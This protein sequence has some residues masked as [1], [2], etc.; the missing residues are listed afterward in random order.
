MSKGGIGP[1]QLTCRLW[2]NPC[3]DLEEEAKVRHPFRWLHTCPCLSSQLSPPPQRSTVNYLPRASIAI[4]FDSVYFLAFFYLL[5]FPHK[6]PDHFLEILLSSTNP[7]QALLHFAL[8]EFLRSRSSP[9]LLSAGGEVGLQLHDSSFSSIY[10]SPE[11]LLVAFS[12][13]SQHPPRSPLWPSALIC[14]NGSV[15]AGGCR[16]RRELG[17]RAPRPGVQCSRADSGRLS[18]SLPEPAHSQV[19]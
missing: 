12:S 6:P 14:Q 11:S 15:P 19:G 18:R 8:V 1:R 2:N 17:P 13:F 7:P 4:Y 10:C 5:L 9:C 16:L 3:L